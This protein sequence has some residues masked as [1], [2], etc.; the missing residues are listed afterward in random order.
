MEKTVYWV[1]HPTDICMLQFR[2]NGVIN[3]ASYPFKP[4]HQ[5]IGA[6][7]LWKIKKKEPFFYCYAAVQGNKRC[8]KQCWS[9]L[10]DCD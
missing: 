6:V 8:D 1:I 3:F 2:H 10:P 7:C 4:H 5:S 9:C